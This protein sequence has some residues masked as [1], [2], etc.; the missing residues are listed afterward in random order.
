M[1]LAQLGRHAEAVPDRD[2]AVDLSPPP[3][4]PRH[5]AL[6]ATSRAQAGQTAEA[7]AEVAELTKSSHW[8]ADQ[9]YDF[10]CVY[11]LAAGRDSTS[12][13][14]HAIRAV[15]LLR[16]AV[17]AGY[18]DAAHMAA[19]PDLAALKT[20]NDFREVLARLSGSHAPNPSPEM[21]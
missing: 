19:D 11:A 8:N 14:A 18:R 7:V 12:R 3:E 2:R 10:A 6:R 5:R 16:R 4:V 20:R 21:K 17:A 15:E 1:A 9:W 13:E